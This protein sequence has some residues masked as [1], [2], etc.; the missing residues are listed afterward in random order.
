MKTKARL[1]FA[2]QAIPTH[3]VPKQKVRVLCQD[4]TYYETRITRMLPGGTHAE[5]EW[6]GGVVTVPVECMKACR[7]RRP[8]SK[9]RR[10]SLGVLGKPQQFEARI[11]ALRITL[12][13]Q[14][15]EVRA[16][17]TA[18][19]EDKQCLI[20]VLEAENGELKESVRRHGALLAQ[21]RDEVRG[22]KGLPP[23]RIG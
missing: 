2:H 10:A 20:E 9:N 21:L 8:G 18:Q 22:L 1:Y 6:D 15:A 3:F 16:T 13:A 7:G 19:L 4:N 5:V 23:F 11:T 14:L 12:T 17:L